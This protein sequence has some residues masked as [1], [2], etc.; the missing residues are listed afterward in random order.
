VCFVRAFV[1]AHSGGT[2]E[3]A[4]AMTDLAGVIGAVGGDLLTYGGS[5]VVP[6]SGI[7]S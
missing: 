1:R 2:G 3:Q 7:I 4:S 5:H 6:L